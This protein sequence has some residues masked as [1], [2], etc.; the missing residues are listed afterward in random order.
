MKLLGTVTT[1][2]LEECKFY[3]VWSNTYN[4]KFLFLLA[5]NPRSWVNPIRAQ[6]KHDFRASNQQ[7]LS[8]RAGQDIYI[9]PREIQNTQQ[10]LN[11]GWVLATLDNQTSGIINILEKHHFYH[12]VNAL[13]FVSGII[14]LD[15]VQGPQQLSTKPNTDMVSIVEEIQPDA[16]QTN[17]NG[18][19]PDCSFPSMNSV[20]EKSQ[21]EIMQQV[22]AKEV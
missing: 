19:I 16:S 20:M 4:W 8:I 3:D 14:P 10:L 22:I 2:A 17:A 5:K 7:E 18:N 21:E 12:F 13:L 1:S 15:Y 6:V 11:T 9:A